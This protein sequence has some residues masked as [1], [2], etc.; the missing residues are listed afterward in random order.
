VLVAGA[1][2]GGED[3]E[4]KWLRVLEEEGKRFTQQVLLVRSVLT[5]LDRGWV[6][7]TPG[8]LGI[9]FVF[10]LS[11]SLFIRCSAEEQRD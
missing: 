11:F 9:W 6:L 4:E 8:V 1:A 10:V 3:A 5:Q 7:V 2:E